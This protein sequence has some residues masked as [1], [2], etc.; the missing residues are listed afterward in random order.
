MTLTELTNLLRDRK[1]LSE[2]ELKAVCDRMAEGNE[3]YCLEEIRRNARL[4]EFMNRTYV[5]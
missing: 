4:K 2:E 5:L 3:K 1:A